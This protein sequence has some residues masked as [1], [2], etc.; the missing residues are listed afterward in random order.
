MVHVILVCST[1]YHPSSHLS[2][3]DYYV[4]NPYAQFNFL[5][6]VDEVYREGVSCNYI[7]NA[8]SSIII[9]FVKQS[10]SDL[11]SEPSAGGFP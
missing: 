6:I 9:V 7:K 1:V 4:C 11:Y 10:F 5:F 8:S 2:Y 3:L